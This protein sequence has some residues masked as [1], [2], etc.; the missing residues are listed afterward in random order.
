MTYPIKYFHRAVTSLIKLLT[1]HLQYHSSFLP[2]PPIRLDIDE[3][4]NTSAAT[5][6]DSTNELLLSTDSITVPIILPPESKDTTPT[7]PTTYLYQILS[8]VYAPS[9]T[10]SGFSPIFPP[11]SPF[12][13]PAGSHISIPSENSPLTLP[14]G[15]NNSSLSSEPVDSTS[16]YPYPLP[17][18]KKS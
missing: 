7:S 13:T 12:Q 3:C 1:R 9:N 17:P 4:A 5:H 14:P 11:E 2:T 6:R 8:P 16:V 10:P 15:D 18:K